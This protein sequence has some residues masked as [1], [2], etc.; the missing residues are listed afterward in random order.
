MVSGPCGDNWGDRGKAGSNVRV[1]TVGGSAATSSQ[2]HATNCRSS[3]NVGPVGTRAAGD[4]SVLTVAQLV[5]DRHGQV[6][7]SAIIVV[8]SRGCHVVACA[9]WHHSLNICCGPRREGSTHGGGNPRVVCSRSRAKRIP[10]QRTP[11]V[12]SGSANVGTRGPSVIAVNSAQQGGSLGVVL[13]AANVV[14]KVD[15]VGVSWGEYCR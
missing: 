10:S 4:R 14:T 9:S 11:R 5:V 1:H 8:S 3:R 15:V 6:I 12:A 7:D 2:N 13:S